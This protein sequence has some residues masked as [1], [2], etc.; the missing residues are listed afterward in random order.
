MKF[1]GYNFN[2]QILT[3]SHHLYKNSIYVKWKW[4]F[5]T[6]ILWRN[7]MLRVEME[8]VKGG[9]PCITSTA[10]FLMILIPRCGDTTYLG[11]HFHKCTYNRTIFNE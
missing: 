10:I 3:H 7:G 8:R 4:H 2:F 11:D 9:T 5:E 6:K 1:L